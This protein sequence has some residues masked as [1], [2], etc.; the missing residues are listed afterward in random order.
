MNAQKKSGGQA[1]VMVSLAVFGTE[2][3]SGWIWL[4]HFIQS[5]GFGTAPPCRGAR[6]WA[7]WAVGSSVSCAT[8]PQTCVLFDCARVDAAQEALGRSNHQVRFTPLTTVQLRQQYPHE[9][10]E[11]RTSEVIHAQT[12]WRVT[13]YLK[14]LN[15]G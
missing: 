3:G 1:I 8:P 14:L 7:V 6:S 12:H 4:V 11:R 2:Y 9:G 13:Q 10:L 15:T 5:A